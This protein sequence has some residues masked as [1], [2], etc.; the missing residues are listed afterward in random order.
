[1]ENAQNAFWNQYYHCHMIL[2]LAVGFPDGMIVLDEP[3]AGYMT[4][5]MRWPNSPLRASIIAINTQRELDGEQ[6]I[7]LGGDKIFHII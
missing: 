5:P 1:M 3:N 2:W 6:I 7:R 4:D